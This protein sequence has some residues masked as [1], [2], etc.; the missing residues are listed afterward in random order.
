[1]KVITDAVKPPQRSQNTECEYRD[2]NAL[3]LNVISSACTFRLF[4]NARVV[5]SPKFYG[6]KPTAFLINTAP[7][8]W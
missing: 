3:L 1:M 7:G 4:R 6:M 8:R 2:M 5:H